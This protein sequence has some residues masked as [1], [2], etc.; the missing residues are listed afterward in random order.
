MRAIDEEDREDLAAFRFDE[1][2][3]FRALGG[4][5]PVGEKGFT[6][7]E[8]RSTSMQ[9]PLLVDPFHPHP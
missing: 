2:A 4:A 3:E 8:R 1:A 6:T 9:K 5:H 7:L